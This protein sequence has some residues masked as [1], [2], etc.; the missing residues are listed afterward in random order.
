MNEASSCPAAGRG[1]VAPAGRRR[2]YLAVRQSPHGPRYAVTDQAWPPPLR[3]QSVRWRGAG[4]LPWPC[5][6]PTIAGPSGSSKGTAEASSPRAEYAVI[7]LIGAG[8]GTRIGHEARAIDGDWAQSEH[9]AVGQP[10]REVADRRAHRPV[11]GLGGAGGDTGEGDGMGSVGAVTGEQS[12]GRSAV[13]HWLPRLA[14]AV[15]G[16]PALTRQRLPSTVPEAIGPGGGERAT[17]LVTTVASWHRGRFRTRLGRLLVQQ[18]RDGDTRPRS[19]G[20]PRRPRG[21]RRTRISRALP[22][23]PVHR[24]RAWRDRLERLV[25]PPG[26]VMLVS[27]AHC[28]PPST[29]SLLL[30]ESGQGPVTPGS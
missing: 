5:H 14:P 25:E 2:R 1:R 12:C 17:R 3:S 26:Q 19:P 28:R 16:L 30:P 29:S 27:D 4:R 15:P 13:K 10:D 7:L 24:R 23:R 11:R 22:D 6:R 8:R 20:P 9:R 21:C 18:G